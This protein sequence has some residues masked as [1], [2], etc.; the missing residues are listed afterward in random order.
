MSRRLTAGGFSERGDGVLNMSATLNAYLALTAY[1]LYL[2]GEKRLI[3]GLNS[4]KGI[5]DIQIEGPT[6]TIAQG[7]I[8]SGGKAIDAALSYLKQEGI[9]FKTETDSAGMQMISSLAG[10][11]AKLYGGENRWRLAMYRGSWMLQE[12]AEVGLHL[13]DGSRLLLYYGSENTNLIDSVEVEWTYENGQTI[14]GRPFANTPF[15]MY[16]TKSNRKLGGLPAP[17]ITVTLNGE[18]KVTDAK[19]KVAFAGQSPGVHVV[20][21]TGYRN[22]AAPE[23]A[24][25]IYHL[26][27]SAPELASFDDHDKVA[28]WAIGNMVNALTYGYIQG[29]SAKAN[30]LAPKK[31]LTR[32]EFVTMLLRL[33]HG[34]T[35]LPVAASPFNDVPASKWYSDEIG[36]AAELGITDRKSGQ[37]EPERA[38]T[39]EEA[40]IMS[41]NAGSLATYGS[42]K[43][44]AF[45]DIAGLS[46]DSLHAIQAV[47]EHKVMIGSDGKFSPKQTLIRE[48]AAAILAR[49]HW[50][51]YPETFLDWDW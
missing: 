25:N 50:V 10:I 34:F 1:K 12:N 48:Q 29:V 31:A 43:R 40:A 28:D 8:P 41:A 46:A 32:A 35:D 15:I 37:F 18:K 21:L 36:R 30:V 20:T 14:S 24:K 39:R 2:N 5:A 47:N 17:G 51:M 26:T 13:S 11:D 9:D 3:D 7:S 44:M 45:S 27:V 6:G 23:V 22:G 16:V 49:L 19:G 38:I 4:S 42:A 33:V